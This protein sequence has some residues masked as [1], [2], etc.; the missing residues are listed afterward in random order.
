MR[1]QVLLAISRAVSDSLLLLLLRGAHLP[2]D[3]DRPVDHHGRHACPAFPGPLQRANAPQD[4]GRFPGHPAHRNGW[5]QSAAVP[6]GV[7]HRGWRRN[8]LR[9]ALVRHG[10]PQ[11]RGGDPR[12]GGRGAG[13]LP[14]RPAL[15]V[16]V[17]ARG[18]RGRRVRRN[19]GWRRG[20]GERERALRWPETGEL[21]WRFLGERGLGAA[22]RGGFAKVQQR[23]RHSH[24][25]LQ[26][27]TAGATAQFQRLG[28][29]GLGERKDICVAAYRVARDHR[30]GHRRKRPLL[31]RGGAVLLRRAGLPL[32]RGK[33]RGH[34]AA[35]PMDEGI[36]SG[37]P[38]GGSCTRGTPSA[39]H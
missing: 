24:R 2:Y 30:R 33:L 8:A 15:G 32:V 39:D 28:A 4:P 18:A 1:G 26:P 21:P 38:R 29:D 16:P 34:A 17:P 19:R 37:I 13:R 3:L 10:V 7:G 22:R 9:S 35:R 23:E 31:Q 14:R 25:Q 36:A 20:G 5:H 11:P 12:A 27:V 6:H